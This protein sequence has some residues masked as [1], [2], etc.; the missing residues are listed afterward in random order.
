MFQSSSLKVPSRVTVRPTGSADMRSD[1][2]RGLSLVAEEELVVADISESVTS[3]EELGVNAAGV[4][5]PAAG[6]EA[7]AVDVFESATEGVDATDVVV[8][9]V[10]EP[11]LEPNN[12]ALE[13][14]GEEVFM[15]QPPGFEKFGAGGEKLGHH[16]DSFPLV[17]KYFRL[18][19]EKDRPAFME[20]VE[21]LRQEFEQLQKEKEALRL[22]FEVMS[23]KY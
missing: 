9:P 21:T 18:L 17:M 11:S 10:H 4:S 15:D 2:T 1:S 14:A 3:G 23:S 19:R 20:A 22:M 5:E 8:S 6:S 13:E 12:V 16:Q 7:P